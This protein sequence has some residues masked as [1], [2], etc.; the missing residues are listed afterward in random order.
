MGAVDAGLVEVFDLEGNLSRTL[1]NPSPAPLDYFGWSLA[2]EGE[3][4]VVGAYLDDTFDFDAGAAHVF[5]SVSGELLHTLSSPDIDESDYF[6]IA[7]AISDDVIAVGARRA[8]IGAV[9]DGAVYLFDATSGEFLREIA[10]P[11][12]ENFD[13]YGSSVAL[14]GD[15]LVVGDNRDNTGAAGSGAAYVFSVTAGELV[16]ALILS[17]IHI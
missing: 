16:H 6:G 17:L 8:D 11:T 9:D 2:A 1:L 5:S 7:V 14:S 15:L 3:H 4:I 10:N 12:S 13:S